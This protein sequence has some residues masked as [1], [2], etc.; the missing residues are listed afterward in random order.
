[1]AAFLQTGYAQYETHHKTFTDQGVQERFT[2][3]RTGHG[4]NDGLLIGLRNSSRGA[5]IQLLEKWP[6]LF[7]TSAVERMRITSDGKVGI[8]TSNPTQELDVLGRVRVRNLPNGAHQLITAA[9]D[10]SLTRLRFSGNPNFVLRANGT[11]GPVPSDADWFRASSTSPPFSITNNIYTLGRV[12]VGTNNPDRN[13]DVRGNARISN[14]PLGPGI[15]LVT[16]SPDGTLRRNLYPNNSNLVLRGDGVFGPVPGDNWGT[17][18]A[19]TDA[20]IN[21]DG[22]SGNELSVNI[23]GDANN[24]LTLGTD[25]ALYA[26]SDPD[27]DP[28][29]ELQTLNRN[30]NNVALSNGGTV[31]I[32]DD[33]ADPTNELNTNLQLNGSSLELTDGGGTLNVDLSSLSGTGDQDWLQLNGTLPTSITDDIYT[34]GNVAIG[35]STPSSSERLHVIGKTRLER[36]PSGVTINSGRKVLE[37]HNDQDNFLWLATPEDK[38]SA[39]YSAHPGAGIFSAGIEFNNRNSNVNNPNGITFKTNVGGTWGEIAM[40]IREDKR[41][42]IGFT[43][44][45]DIMAKLH[46]RGQDNS[47]GSSNFLLENQS[48]NTLVDVKNDGKV[49]IGLSNPT[50]HFHVKS[51]TNTLAG[52]FENNSAYN[53][54]SIQNDGVVTSGELTGTTGH[55]YS[56]N[57]GGGF[58]TRGKN[59]GI[60]KE[61]GINGSIR[62]TNEI[63]MYEVHGSDVYQHASKELIVSANATRFDVY[64]DLKVKP[65]SQGGTGRLCV[66]CNTIDDLS[67]TAAASI[68]GDAVISGNVGIGTGTPTNK[69][70]VNPGSSGVSGLTLSGLNSNPTGKVLSVVDG[71][72]EVILVDGQGGDGDPQNEL[73][74]LDLNGNTLSLTDDPTPVDLSPY[75]DNTDEQTLSLSGSDLSISGGNTVNLGGIGLTAC[76]SLSAADNNFLT[77]WSD[78]NLKEICRSSIFENNAGFVRIGDDGTG[79]IGLGAARLTINANP[80]NSIRAAINFSVQNGLRRFIFGFDGNN[81][82]AIRN[83]YT[84]N[85]PFVINKNNDDVYFNT[86]HFNI[87]GDDPSHLYLRLNNTNALGTDWFFRSA[88]TSFSGGI[89]EGSLTIDPDGAVDAIQRFVLTPEMKVGIGQGFPDARLHVTGLPQTSYAAKFE[90]ANGN[91]IFHARNDGL[92]IANFALAI[93]GEPSAAYSGNSPKLLIYGNTNDVN[94]TQTIS[95]VNSDGFYANQLRSFGRNGIALA[96]SSAPTTNS[97]LFKLFNFSNH[98]RAGIGFF[99][100]SEIPGRVNNVN[101]GGVLHVRNEG[102]DPNNVRTILSEDNNDNGVVRH[103]F[104]ANSA[105]STTSEFFLITTS[106]YNYLVGGN[107][108]GAATNLFQKNVVLESTA[109]ADDFRFLSR[110]PEGLSFWTQIGNGVF[111]HMRMLNNGNVGIGAATPAAKLDVHG[112]I[113]INSAFHA[114]DKR[115]KRN[116][117]AI[118]DAMS[119][120][121]RL[122]GVSY[123]FRMNEFKEMNFS[124]GNQLGL[125]A[126]ELEKVFPELVKT[127]PDGY[128]IVNYDG[129]IPVLIEGVK[130]QQQ[131]IDKLENENTQIR[132]EM[133]ELKGIV[134]QFAAKFEQTDKIVNRTRVNLGGAQSVILDQNAP[135]P[136]KERTTIGYVVPEKVE[137]AQIFIFDLNGQI[138]K[139]V[140][141]Q[142]GEGVLEVFASNLSSGMYS[143]S[144]VIDGKVMNTKKM[145]VSK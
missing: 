93:N 116:I 131:Q 139:K 19:A 33:D 144:L 74:D 69:L 84:G 87:Q 58:V 106:A 126:Q 103:S 117:E 143:Y 123:Q 100:N 66:N 52:K 40:Q 75:L 47:S 50:A 26:P 32:E 118:S 20:T 129:L 121:S 94:D 95:M 24:E 90:S 72:G 31:S 89:E 73:Q 39:I 128:K 80:S 21:G 120:I 36:G 78:A 115:F 79:N 16:A 57:E 6:L 11:F 142:A 82:I 130:E 92:S 85:S 62:S 67:T 55:F 104:W 110:S 65:V 61:A 13:L 12:G 56:A 81:D 18:T 109:A 28:T 17:Q 25:G 101:R 63:L 137:D 136:F 133:E 102:A 97:N 138:M 141:L 30:G 37:I 7:S 125:I 71:T 135:N 35:T 68:V 10:G 38:T 46:V 15:Q 1:M 105:P 145:V 127:K 111:E 23:S 99:G 119:K 41:V 83:A 29:N 88:A 51:L 49:G 134:K 27:N 53:L 113:Y 22:A 112:D 77:K 42:G 14:M 44:A 98:A 86:K 4:G 48:A 70:D 45:N 54:L 59:F 76:P 108:T 2:N 96:S 114:S 140:P 43:D 34:E 5:Y 132:R 60:V 122:N 3:N 107:P 9:P 8:G 91:Q 64:S 124:E